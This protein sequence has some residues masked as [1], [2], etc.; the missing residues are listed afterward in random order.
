MWRTARF[1]PVRAMEIRL[2]GAAFI[3]VAQSLPCA[4]APA[5]RWMLIRIE[6]D[7][8]VKENLPRA[9]PTYRRCRP[10]S[11]RVRKTI[12]NPRLTGSEQR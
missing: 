1:Y 2:Y 4:R 3:F 6:G 12:R 8:H 10:V 9:W 11:Y 5:L 7:V